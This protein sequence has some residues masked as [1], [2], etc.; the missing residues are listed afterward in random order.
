MSQS[1]SDQFSADFG[2][3][4][5]HV[6]NSYFPESLPVNGTVGGTSALSSLQDLTE[7]ANGLRSTSIDLTNGAG[8]LEAYAIFALQG[9]FD[10]AGGDYR[11][12]L[13]TA[14]DDARL[15]AGDSLLFNQSPSLSSLAGSIA[16]GPDA[17]LGNAPV[18][19]GTS[20]QLVRL[21]QALTFELPGFGDL[22]TGALAGGS[23]PEFVVDMSRTWLNSVAEV[24]AAFPGGLGMQRVFRVRNG[25]LTLPD[26]VELSNVVI[27]VE[28]GDINFN[29]AGQRLRNVTLV[30]E[31]G[32]VNL[33]GVDARKVSVMASGS[34]HVN[35]EARFSGENRL[36]T[37]KGNVFFDGATTTASYGWVK[38]VSGG[39][40]TFNAA[41]ETLGEFWA[42]RNFTVNSDSLLRGSIRAREDV[43]ANAK[44][45]MV[46][47]Q[48]KLV[49]DQPLVGI[50]D[51][52][53]AANNPDIDPSRIHLGK[54]YVAG[55]SNPLLQPGPGSQHGTFITGIIAATAGNGIGIDGLTSANTPIY[56]ARAIGSG[57][58]AQALRDFVDYSKE[59]GQPHAIANLSLDLTQINADGTVTTRYEF[60]PQERDALEYARRNNVLIVAAAGNTGDIMS[61]LGQS[62]QEFDNIITVGAA[63]GEQRA[64]YSGYGYGLDVLAEG[65]SATNPVLS[66]VGDGVGSMAGTSI[67]AA[68]V[69]ALASQLWEANSGLSNRQVIDLIR[70]T[71]TDVGVAGWDE[72]SGSGIVDPERALAKALV[73]APEVAGVVAAFTTPTTWGGDGVV[74]PIERAAEIVNVNF[75]ARVKP[76]DGV[77]VRT[78]PGR[79]Y[80]RVT[81]FPV[82]SRVS[83][84]GWTH[85]EPIYDAEA[86]ANDARWY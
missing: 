79:E 10:N 9:F 72:Q 21:A 42:A 38:V 34:I 67:A 5:L 68:R 12:S 22:K 25:G 39:D 52:G 20:D 17:R 48:L 35:R 80:P 11:G 78:G 44:F 50:I 76:V 33:S 59:V 23:G 3:D 4:S 73:T 2:S 15:Y 69:T 32:N 66:T 85:G 18:G 74:L 7:R 77:N 47:E 54:D 30:A 82:N 63:D 26:G 13:D 81:G 43:I 55:D 83:F 8:A 86:G 37:E 14:A 49:K 51:T 29:G 71:T 19:L 27:I 65:G 75:T 62:S 60:T 64:D 70:S 58:W 31:N 28:Q 84:D 6:T 36:A 40:I 56:V 46:H 61:V 24:A 57:G 1:S 53:L 16:L 45:R 41:A